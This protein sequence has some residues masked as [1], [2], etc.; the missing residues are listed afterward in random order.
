MCFRID[1]EAKRPQQRVG[2]KVVKFTRGHYLRSTMGSG[3]EW[4]TPGATI[5]RSRGRTSKLSTW[6]PGRTACHGIYVCERLKDARRLDYQ[7]DEIIIKV[8]V[9]P[10]D[11]LHSNDR[12]GNDA[13]SHISTYDKVTI[14]KEQPY[15]TWY[16]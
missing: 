14:A 13:C 6:S 15:L 10:A 8:L 12:W 1:S 4:S 2:Y 16:D 9:D 11:W 5:R 3:Q 7:V